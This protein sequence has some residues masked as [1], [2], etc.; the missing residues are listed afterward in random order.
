M[1]VSG[2]TLSLLIR[3]GALIG[4]VGSSKELRGHSPLV[5]VVLG[6][7]RDHVAELG[8]RGVSIHLSNAHYLQRF[9]GNVWSELSYL[10]AAV[11]LKLAHSLSLGDLGVERLHNLQ[12]PLTR[13]GYVVARLVRVEAG[14]YWGSLSSPDGFRSSV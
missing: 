7:A 13:Y 10:L 3:A 11:L 5:F 2:T 1:G 8:Q 4:W 14:I 9:S 6:I 12:V